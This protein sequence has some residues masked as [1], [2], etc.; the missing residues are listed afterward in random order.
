M[1]DCTA[2]TDEEQ[3]R[4]LTVR[5]RIEVLAKYPPDVR[6]VVDGYEDGYDNLDVQSLSTMSVRHKP[7]HEEWE[8]ENEDARWDPSENDFSAV[9]IARRSH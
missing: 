1:T 6:V 9:R 5:D 2:D 4:P 3:C 7:D 8:G